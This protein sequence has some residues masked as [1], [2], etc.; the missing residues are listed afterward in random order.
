MVSSIR[1]GALP[2]ERARGYGPQPLSRAERRRVL[3]E[4]TF[5]LKERFGR[6]LVA[7][8]AYGSTARGA[9]RPYSDLEL[10]CVL[11]GED[12]DL[13]LEWSV[14]AWKAEVDVR[15][16]EVLVREAVRLE[17]TWPITHG[18]YVEIMPL[19]GDSDVFERVRAAALGHGDDEFEVAIHSLIVGE[20][21]ELT[22]KVRNL[23]ASGGGSAT[24]LLATELGKYAA[25]LVGLA[26]RHLYGTASSVFDESLTLPV[27]PGGYD[28][29][30]A[31]LTGPGIVDIQQ[32]A[33]AADRLWEGIEIWAGSCDIELYEETA[34]VLEQ[35]TVD[36]E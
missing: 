2:S 11:A 5:A 8:G 25:C 1:A 32:V 24:A 27:R 15:S 13:D 7:L 29:L 31:L 18:A 23:H 6:D 28:A 16:E 26:N 3:D 20:L 12:V 4:I 14:G 22:G 9:D 36:T 35:A 19:L 10:H 34:Q 33:L 17:G 30:H 21:Y